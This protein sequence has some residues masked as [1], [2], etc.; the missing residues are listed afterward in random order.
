MQSH[1]S[2]SH[3]PRLQPNESGS[4]F[5]RSHSL[6]LPPKPVNIPIPPS[7][8]ESPYLTSPHSI[9]RRALSNPPAPSQ[10]DEDWLQDTVPLSWEARNA[11]GALGAAKSLLS[12][13]SVVVRRDE[14]DCTPRGRGTDRSKEERKLSDSLSSPPLVRTPKA[15]VP[16]RTSSW[17]QRT[18]NVPTPQNH[19][20]PLTSTGL[21]RS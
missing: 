18:T 20:H 16:V 4:G 9:F 5:G 21:S 2:P 14:E 11:Q 3:P 6:R 15:A 17:N 1:P 19:H 13:M 8:A 12:G 10:E 7:L